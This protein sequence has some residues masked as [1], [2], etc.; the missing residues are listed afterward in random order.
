MRNTT[1]FRR[2]A[3]GAPLLAAAIL[4]AGA[5]AGLAQ[6]TQ[7]PAGSSPAPSAA[8]ATQ[9]ERMTQCNAEAGKRSLTG[10][11]RRPFMSECLA[12][13][14]PAAPAGTPTAAQAAQRERM[15]QCN[16]DAGTRGLAADA[17]RDFM[18]NCLAGRSPSGPAATGG[19]RG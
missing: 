14:M 19:P 2:G 10:D 8:Q 18:R 9:R 7:A 15:A 6:G 4:L 11:A 12:G 3:L 17:R 16:A 5:S 1:L 13:R